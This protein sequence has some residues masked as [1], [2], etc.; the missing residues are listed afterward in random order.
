M[1]KGFS[2]SQDG[3]LNDA[4]LNEFQVMCFSAPLQPEEL[5][6]VK[7]VVSQKMPQV[8]LGVFSP[9]GLALHMQIL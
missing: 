5:A 2:G 3:V 7:K 6:G 1:T 4:E 8:R 9:A